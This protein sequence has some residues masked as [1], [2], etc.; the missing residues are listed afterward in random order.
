M[1]RVNIHLEEEWLRKLDELMNKIKY[2]KENKFW[3]Q[4]LTRADLIRVA[5]AKYF[6]FNRLY[7]HSWG[8]DIDDL[9]KKVTRKKDLKKG[10]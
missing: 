6:S 4:G 7:T 8:R 2:S 3:V 10:V 5:I 9:I 1:K